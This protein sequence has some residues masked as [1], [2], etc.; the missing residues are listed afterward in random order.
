MANG[1]FIATNDPP[2]D[3]EPTDW[4]DWID[5]TNAFDISW[6]T[7][8]LAA[9]GLIACCA[10][11]CA[12][13]RWRRNHRKE[14]RLIEERNIIAGAIAG[15]HTGV[16]NG[17]KVRQSFARPL[18]V[19]G[20]VRQPSTLGESGRFTYNESWRKPGPRSTS[21]QSVFSERSSV[22][23]GAGA[24][25]PIMVRA[26]SST[27]FTPPQEACPECGLL[28]S[29]VVQLVSHVEAQHGGRASR[30]KETATALSVAKA[31]AAANDRTGGGSGRTGGGSGN[32]EGGSGK[33][34]TSGPTKGSGAR[35]GVSGESS[36]SGSSGIGTRV[37]SGRVSPTA[38]EAAARV[39]VVTSKSMPPTT[40]AAGDKSAG[41]S[42]ER[43][44]GD[45]GRPAR[46]TSHESAS[47]SRSTSTSRSGTSRSGTGSGSSSRGRGTNLGRTSA[48]DGR[49][50][51]ASTDDRSGNTR[52]GSR[53]ASVRARGTG[54]GRTSASHVRATSASTND[55]YGKTVAGT[56]ST[57]SRARGTGSERASASNGRPTPGSTDDRYDNTGQ[58]RE[59]RILP[60][61]RGAPRGGEDTL[62]NQRSG[63]PST[64]QRMS[65]AAMESASAATAALAAAASRGAETK[66]S[67]AAA[68][69]ANAGAPS[70]SKLLGNDSRHGRPATRLK[71]L[72]PASA[73]SGVRPPPNRSSADSSGK[74][75][76][77]RSASGT[78]TS[79]SS[80][81]LGVAEI[82]ASEDFD[83]GTARVSRARTRPSNTSGGGVGVDGRRTDMARGHSSGRLHRANSWD[84]VNSRASSLD[85][86]TA[87]SSRAVAALRPGVDAPGEEAFGNEPRIL[88]PGI[89]TL[90]STDDQIPV[91]ER[92]TVDMLRELGSTGIAYAVP[93]PVFSPLGPNFNSFSDSKPAYSPVDRARAEE[94]DALGIEHKNESRT[95]KFFRQL[96]S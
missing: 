59:G 14:A 61:A 83:V 50:K 7:C 51:S 12:C 76:G 39:V 58:R 53:S 68:G 65:A 71:D 57:N 95:K 91:A 29:D 27:R 41:R 72:L 67:K 2:A 79:S 5:S 66:Q 38:A 90:R 18:P 44:P 31:E 54:S 1:E 33:T 47:Q 87:L 70:A 63:S 21:A 6:Q 45:S 69:T 8:V 24:A 10:G 35:T 46:S 60:R 62:T 20:P 89:R 16:A 82:Y 15:R 73:S 36:I 40:V 9:L 48:S 42:R 64:G 43:E 96:S 84:S 13:C 88:Y 26:G 49:A 93:A 81:R 17:R 92:L 22:L 52:A 19:P 85:R 11:T 78:V 74:N 75:G 28:L 80:H 32:T 94:R 4:L 25:V 30:K 37:G 56:E 3:P 55:R 23:T 34:A 77:S 86:P